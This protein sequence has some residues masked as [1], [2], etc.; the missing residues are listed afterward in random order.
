MINT[1]IFKCVLCCLMYNIVEYCKDNFF[2]RQ[3]KKNILGFPC[4]LV[5][6]NLPANAGDIGSSPISG[7]FHMPREN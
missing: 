3:K 1:Q 6:N 2:V 4:S 5:V 7:R